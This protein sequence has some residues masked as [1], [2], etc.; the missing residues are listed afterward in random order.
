MAGMLVVPGDI[1][2]SQT[3]SHCPRVVDSHIFRYW[4][5]GSEAVAYSTLATAVGELLSKSFQLRTTAL[6]RIWSIRPLAFGSKSVIINSLFSAL[7]RSRGRQ[8]T[9][10]SSG[11]VNLWPA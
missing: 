11:L 3:R 6:S 8:G 2:Y 4:R 10:S 9:V 7:A 5:E 1:Q